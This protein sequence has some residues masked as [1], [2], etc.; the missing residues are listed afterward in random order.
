MSGP[1]VSRPVASAAAAFLLVLLALVAGCD[2]L[3]EQVLLNIGPRAFTARDLREIHAAMDAAARPALATREEREAFVS[4]IVERVLLEEYGESLVTAGEADVEAES[5][6][7]R[8]DALIRRLRVLLG[9]NAPL[10]SVTARNAY[11]RMCVLHRVRTVAFASEEEA[12]RARQRLEPGQGLDALPEYARSG[13]GESWIAWSASSDPIA[14]ELEGHEVGDIVGPFPSRTWWR[15]VELLGHRPAELEPYEKIRGRILG[16][17]RAREELLRTRELLAERLEAENLRIDGEKVAW[18]AA[19]TREAIL[20]PGATEADADWAVPRLDESDLATV[21]AEWKTGRFTA[22]DYVGAVERMSRGQRPRSSGL[23]LTVHGLVED[24]V[25]RRLLVAE[26]E[27]RRLDED[28]WVRQ[29]LR[30]GRAERLIRVAIQRI[31]RDAVVPGDNESLMRALRESQPQ[32]LRSEPKARL[33]RMDLPTRELA[34]SE[35]AAI[36]RA[37]GGR[38]RL[39]E[40][41]SMPG[42]VPGAYHLLESNA[43]AITEPAVREAVFDGET[44][45]PLGPFESVGAWF[46]LVCL[47]IEPPRDV[48]V[49]ELSG[50]S[51]GASGPEAVQQW[52][53]ERREAVGV[54]VNRDALDE[55]GPG[56]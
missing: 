50:S 45:T 7:A 15:L 56:G 37:G 19:E 32:L 52:I 14:E 42:P 2:E 43:S 31:E 13:G 3:G 44:G 6:V 18:L 26:A 29:A 10:D 54:S 46:V 33:L 30:S 22:G 8:E 21:V 11:E 34:E 41:L 40:I 1:R 9:S 4:A 12:R 36:A 47:E 24:G 20:R 28:R 16:S 17:L 23:Q 39:R 55:I 48:D 25:E 35:V 53:R 5:D 49:E 38:E 27:R 51:L